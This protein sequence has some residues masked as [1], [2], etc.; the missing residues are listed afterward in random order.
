MIGLMTFGGFWFFYDGK[1]GWPKKNIVAIA[2]L[3]F[4]AAADGDSWD[5]FRAKNDEIF[6]D[7]AFADGSDELELVD[8]AH[9]QGGKPRSWIDYK[10]SSAGRD[11][12]GR[13][14]DE[15][16]LKQA[17]HAGAKGSL[18]WGEYARDNE[19][20]ANK[21]E[22]TPEA[23]LGQYGWVALKSAFDGAAK[24]RDWAVYGVT[25][26][27]KG[28]GAK[29]PHYHSRSEING[30]F[31]IAYC[32]WAM[33]LATLGW[34]LF[35]SRRTLSADGESFTT[36]GGT[37]VFFKSVFEIDTRKW[38]KKGLAYVR[39]RN[40]SGSEKRAVIDDLKYKEADE[41]LDRLL[42]NFSGRIIEKTKTDMD[43]G[44]LDNEVARGTATG[45][46]QVSSGDE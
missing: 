37:R 32:L 26:G 44:K 30:Q 8:D 4:D 29:D 11:A 41:I 40:E 28:W 38:D 18:T 31:L 33:A 36:E 16:L 21:E 5:V 45:S 20:P 10:L 2:K 43:E 3:A 34:A 12:L 23:K 22:A 25:S 35:N 14:N 39:Y 7:T 27:R 24:K 13:I 17:F 19:V 42:A 9:K 46:E 1:I 15:T 6:K